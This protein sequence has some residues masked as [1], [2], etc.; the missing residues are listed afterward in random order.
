[1]DLKE[2]LNRLTSVSK[3]QP[4]EKTQ[5]LSDLRQR[6]DRLLEPKKIYQKRAIFPIEQLVKGEVISTPEGETFLSKEQ[7]PPHFRYGEMTLADVLTLPTYPAHLLSKDERLKELDFD[8][9]ITM[10]RES[11]K[12][13]CELYASMERCHT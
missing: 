6:L 3:S 1:M 11:H 5:V 8:R 12:S 4:E 2:R 9:Y 13:M 10:L 7:F